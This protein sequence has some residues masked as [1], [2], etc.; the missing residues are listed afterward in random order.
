MLSLLNPD[1]VREQLRTEYTSLF[2]GETSCSLQDKAN[3]RKCLATD[4]SR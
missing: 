1:L 3:L 4:G 2:L